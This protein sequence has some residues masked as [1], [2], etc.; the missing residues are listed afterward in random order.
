MSEWQFDSPPGIADRD[1]GLAA[2][3][4]KVRYDLTSAQSKLTEAMRMVATLD[5]GEE[6][7]R[8]ECPT[9]GASL[10]GPRTLAEHVH[11]SH[12]GPVPEQWLAI[13]ERS[14]DPQTVT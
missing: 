14:A 2:V 8:I 3:L 7:E 12:G 10:P 11:V 4:R 5:I 6:G 13:E 1:V 9:C